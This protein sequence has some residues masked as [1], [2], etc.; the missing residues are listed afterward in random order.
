MV[1]EYVIQ[2]VLT[3]QIYFI[4][5]MAISR[6]WLGRRGITMYLT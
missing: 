4:S 2:T 3:R 6:L 5:F 1:Y